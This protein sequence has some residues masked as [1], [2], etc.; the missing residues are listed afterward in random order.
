MD[1]EQALRTELITVPGLENKVY[2]VNAPEGTTTPYAT[3]ESGDLAEI[4]VLD[5]FDESGTLECTVD[6]FESTYSEMKSTA[7]LVKAKIK[8]FLSRVIGTNGPYIQN[9]TFAELLPEFYEPNINLYRKS[10]SFTVF[11]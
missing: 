9:V 10:I 8:T 4:K 6:V 11:Y 2:P 1:F 3:Y 5:G 7:G